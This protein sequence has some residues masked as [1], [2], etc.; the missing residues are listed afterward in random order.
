MAKTFTFKTEAGNSFRTDR[1]GFPLIECHRCSGTGRLPQFGNVFG[2]TCFRCSG[3]GVAHVG[4]TVARL[5]AE[6]ASALQ[7]AGKCEVSDIMVGDSVKMPGSDKFGVVSFAK[8]T[9]QFIGGGFTT[10]GKPI[11]MV[12]IHVIV[13]EGRVYRVSANNLVTRNANTP[14]MV[15]LRDRLGSEARAHYGKAL[16]RRTARTAALAA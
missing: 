9:A 4:G 14:A 2:G 1:H 3:A 12:H 5:A 11:H 15:A 10:N 8:R 6:F 13:I 7:R 16:D